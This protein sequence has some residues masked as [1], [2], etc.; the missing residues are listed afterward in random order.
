MT[1]Y[2]GKRV[3]HYRTA[4]IALGR[5]LNLAHHFPLNILVK[6]R[7]IIPEMWLRTTYAGAAGSNGPICFIEQN[8][9]AIII[10][11]RPLASKIVK[12]PTLA[13]FFR[14]K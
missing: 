1:L 13:G 10:C 7:Q 4:K 9:G 11:Y 2:P 3:N 14:I 12:T 6:W 8:L 5:F